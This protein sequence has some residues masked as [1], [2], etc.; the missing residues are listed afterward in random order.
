[1]RANPITPK[2]SK[3]WDRDS[4]RLVL[5]RFDTLE[6]RH[7]EIEFIDKRL[8]DSN[9]NIVADIVIGPA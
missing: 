9:P 8:N 1:L 3:P 2:E 5:N 4:G 6:S 7:V